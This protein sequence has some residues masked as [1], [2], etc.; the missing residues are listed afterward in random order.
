MSSIEA[1]EN[2]GT[3]AAL[4]AKMSSQEVSM[5]HPRPDHEAHATQTTYRIDL[6]HT[7]KPAGHCFLEQTMHVCAASVLRSLCEKGA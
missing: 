7:T 3:M 2:S 4:A 5:R 6:R 1:L